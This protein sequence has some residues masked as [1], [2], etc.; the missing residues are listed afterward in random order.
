MP[1]DDQLVEVY[2]LLLGHPVETEVVEDEQVRGEEGAEGLVRGVVHPGLS[3]G[4]EEVVGM[5]EADGMPGSDGSISEGL[6]D[7]ALAHADRPDE[8]D[9]LVAR[10]ELE[11]E[12]GV[13]KSPVE[14]D[15]CGPVKV[16]EAAGLFEAGP[17]EAEFEPP[18][19]SAVDLIGQYDLQEG[20]VV[21][22]L[23]VYRVTEHVRTASAPSGA[24]QGAPFRPRWYPT[25]AWSGAF[26]TPLR[27][28][29]VRRPLAHA[30][31]QH[32]ARPARRAHGPLSGILRHAPSRAARGARF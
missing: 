21:E 10:Q 22:L 15:G 26:T 16:F 9:V 14:C 31:R 30:V 5:Y 17:L 2:G 20:C 27:R 8:Q 28:S 13:E 1:G 24:G 19:V 3:H 25:K 18:V 12:G 29:G 23:P 4:S 32:A 7:E 6:S 11:R